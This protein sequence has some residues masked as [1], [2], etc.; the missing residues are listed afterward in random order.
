MKFSIVCIR[1]L[2]N[3]NGY[4]GRSENDLGVGGEKSRKEF[5]NSDSLASLCDENKTSSQKYLENRDLSTFCSKYL[6]KN[7]L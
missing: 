7:T 4:V 2:T 6:T 3:I 1:V 5:K